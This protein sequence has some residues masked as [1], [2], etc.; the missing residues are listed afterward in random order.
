MIR[1]KKIL[2][3][4]FFTII[5]INFGIFSNIGSSEKQIIKINDLNNESISINQKDVFIQRVEHFLYLKSEENI[6]GFIVNYSFPPD[7]S[8]QTPI[9]LEIFDDSTA[10]IIKYEI[11]NDLKEPNKFARFTIGLIKKDEIVLIHFTCWVLLFKD[12]FSDLPNDVG[13]P[14]R[15]DIPDQYK[16][17]LSSS[18]VVQKNRFLIKYHAQK[19]KGGNDSLSDFA[20]NVSLFI[21]QHRYFLFIIQ[22]NLK[23]FFSQDA[24]TTLFINGENVG[25]S[26][27]AC[28]LLRSCN[29]P[30]RVLLVNNDQG[31]WTQMHYMIEYYF[32][33]YGWVLIDTTKGETPYDTNRQVINRICYPSDENDTKKDYII[34]FMKGEERWLWISDENIHPYYIDCNEGSKSQMFVEGNITINSFIA[35]QIFFKTQMVFHQY[36][37]F[38]G[39]NLN[40]ENLEY[41][42]TA[43]LYQKKAILE[44]TEKKDVFDYIYYIDKAYDEYKKIEI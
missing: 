39:I 38:L 1:N 12:D 22:L 20:Y 2:F 44:F 30:S 10:D 7:Y 41:L 11:I 28:A 17:W 4:I 18:D 21:K 25:R 31:F 15:K 43:I 19:L 9:L 29:I 36:Q 8:Y 14:E 34:P 26:H 35:D 24:M 5:I 23:V 40:Q 32:P 37:K 42:N 3:Q 13:I 27:L 33:D 16:I 6:E